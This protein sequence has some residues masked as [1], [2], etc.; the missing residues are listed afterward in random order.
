M[1]PIRVG[2][3]RRIAP[4]AGPPVT[5][6]DSGDPGG[7]VYVSGVDPPAEAEYES[8]TLWLNSTTGNLWRWE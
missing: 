7:T 5:V 6:I 3:P 1:T 8:G 2:T 4:S